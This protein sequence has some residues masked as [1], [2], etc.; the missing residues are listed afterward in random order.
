MWPAP[1]LF[2]DHWNLKMF[3]GSHVDC[4]HE[5]ALGAMTHAVLYGTPTCPCCEISWSECNR[6]FLDHDVHRTCYEDLLEDPLGEILRML[7]C[8]GVERN[9][10]DL[11]EA[12]GRQSASSIQTSDDKKIRFVFRRGKAGGYRSELSPALIS[13]IEK[14]CGDLMQIYGYS[15]DCQESPEVVAALRILQ[16]VASPV[17]LLRFGEDPHAYVLVP[18]DLQGVSHW[19]AGPDL[20]QQPHVQKLLLAEHGIEVRGCESDSALTQDSPILHMDAPAWRPELLEGARVVLLNLEDLSLALNPERFQ[21]ELGPL[22]QRLDQD[23]ACVHFRCHRL[24]SPLEVPGFGALVPSALQATFLRRDRWEGRQSRL[25][26]ELPHP[27]ALVPI[28]GAH[29]QMILDAAWCPGMEASQQSLARIEEYRLSIRQ[30]EPLRAAYVRPAEDPAQ[31]IRAA[32]RPG[33]E[34][35]LSDDLLTALHV[36]SFRCHP[37]FWCSG[38]LNSNAVVQCSCLS[39]WRRCSTPASAADSPGQPSRPAVQQYTARRSATVSGW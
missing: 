19:L 17:G 33:E 27:L 32:E 31:L 2:F 20:A 1:G 18:D 39:R 13:R 11:I 12:I 10:A 3:H 37:H 14:G 21:V 15:K 6:E 35:L 26:P 8:L 22:L 5:D 16:P 23:F 36:P 28:Q 29:P 25:A 30:T 4:R 34:E 38:C 9:Q 7:N 24:G